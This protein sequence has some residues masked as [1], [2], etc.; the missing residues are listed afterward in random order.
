[1]SFVYPLFFY[2]GAAVAAGVFILHLL[3]TKQPPSSP[4]PTLRFV[5]DRVATTTATDIKPTDVLVMLTRMLLALA[6]GAALARP[7]INPSH[8]DTLRIIALDA[9]RASKN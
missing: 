6:V 4:L 9:S 3:V 2:A 5:P 8:T 1:M 7:I